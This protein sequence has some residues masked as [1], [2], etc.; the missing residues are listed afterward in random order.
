[1]GDKEL[2]KVAINN[3]LS[4]A[5]KYTPDHGTVTFSLREEHDR[6]IFE[7]IDSGYGI[8]KEDLPFIFNK[9]YRSADPKIREQHGSGFG[10]ALASEI[11][12]LHGGEI[13]VESEPGSGSQFVLAIPKE[14]YHLGN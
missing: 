13:E 9:S 4:N 3:I 10:L 14:A 11:V 7:V 2:L 8:A 5:I 1:V 6:V 12:N